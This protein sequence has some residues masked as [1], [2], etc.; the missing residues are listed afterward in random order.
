ML[1]RKNSIFKRKL[2]RRYPF[3]A[4]SDSICFLFRT[5]CFCFGRNQKKTIQFYLFACRW[6]DRVVVSRVVTFVTG[7]RDT[8]R[9]MRRIQMSSTWQEYR[10]PK[11]GRKDL[12]MIRSST[13][14][15][16]GPECRQV[17]TRS[18][19]PEKYVAYGCCMGGKIHRRVIWKY[20]D[21][22]HKVIVVFEIHCIM[23]HKID[24][25]FPTPIKKKCF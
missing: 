21:Y 10:E 19:S 7:F 25:F 3:A 5:Y 13:F 17:W 1:K 18:N 4:T 22:Y 8:Q 15:C 6:L 24:P 16:A 2:V 14:D 11:K 9:H 20:I 23:L 12:A